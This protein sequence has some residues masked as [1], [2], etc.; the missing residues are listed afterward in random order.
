M[1]AKLSE[2]RRRLCEGIAKGLSKAEAARQAGFSGTTQTL[3]QTAIDCLKIPE[4]ASY[5]QSLTRKAETSRIASVTEVH[6]M[7]SECIR[8]TGADW[9]DR[10]KAGELL[11]KCRGE[12]A[13][14]KLD[15]AMSGAVQVYV[16]SNGRDG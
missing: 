9:K 6:E 14:Q 16:P 13:P 5:L 12:F 8:D 7:W 2:K 11:T 4:V 10:L 15:V 1:S 3:S